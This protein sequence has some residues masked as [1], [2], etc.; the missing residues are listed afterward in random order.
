MMFHFS[1][2]SST[3]GKLK[4]KNKEQHKNIDKKIRIS[5]SD[6]NALGWKLLVKGQSWLNSAGA[7]E[8]WETLALQTLLEERQRHLGSI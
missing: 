8:R 1:F 6:P 5:P 2:V 7:L 4:K 3:S